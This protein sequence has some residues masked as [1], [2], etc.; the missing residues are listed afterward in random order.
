MSVRES[1][2]SFIAAT[3]AED[4]VSAFDAHRM[5]S[6]SRH[7]N[8]AEERDRLLAN[9]KDF[10]TRL[11]DVQRIQAESRDE[12]RAQA[13]AQAATNALVTKSLDELKAK[14]D[15]LVEAATRTDEAR[16]ERERIAETAGRIGKTIATLIAAAVGL[17]S[18]VK[19]AWELSKPRLP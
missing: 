2:P 12:R 10:D 15:A 8:A 13:A 4:I 16:K 11:T 18:F 17:V 6:A 19:I 5:E 3:P 9:V 14:V 7:M 1:R